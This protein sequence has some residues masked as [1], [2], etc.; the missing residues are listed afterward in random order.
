M[1]TFSVGNWTSKAKCSHSPRSFFSRRTGSTATILAFCF[2]SHSVVSRWVID[3]ARQ[4][5]LTFHSA[6]LFAVFVQKHADSIERDGAEVV[7]FQVEI[8][9][10]FQALAIGAVL[11]KPAHGSAEVNF[12]L[13]P[14]LKP[15][16]FTEPA[17][18][19]TLIDFLHVG[20]FLN[21]RGGGR[22]PVA[23]QD[24]TRRQQARQR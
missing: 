13:P 11:I 22:P 14:I 9:R 12:R 1:I 3:V 20:Q 8:E 19:L 16:D 10:A 17:F 18:D 6:H 5:E 7:G 4:G 21:G 2:S 24:W 15:G 23:G